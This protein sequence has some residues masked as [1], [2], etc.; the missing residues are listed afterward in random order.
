VKDQIKEIDVKMTD[1]D[2]KMKQ[3][4]ETF[5]KELVDKRLA[6]AETEHASVVRRSF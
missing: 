4:A 6:T 1:I 2:G 3:Y 5:L